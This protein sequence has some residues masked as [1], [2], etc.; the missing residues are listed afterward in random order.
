MPAKFFTNI[1]SVHDPEN[2]KHHHDTQYEHDNMRP[3]WVILPTLDG[4]RIIILH[5]PF[6]MLE[7]YFLV[8]HGVTI[9]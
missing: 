4:K 3:K 5:R 6:E 7:W 1:I 2:G 9:E 8:S